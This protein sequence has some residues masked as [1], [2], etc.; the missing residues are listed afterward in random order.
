MSAAASRALLVRRRM[1]AAEKGRRRRTVLLSL[2][3]AAA[4]VA[5]GWWVVTGP[6]GRITS[7]EVTGYEGPRKALVVETIRRVAERGSVVDPPVEDLRRAMAAFPWVEDLHV[8]R[9]LP[10][11]ISVIVV[12]ATVGAVAVPDTG[13]PM[14]V[15]ASGR[16][17]GPLPRK[18]PGAPRVRVGTADLTV[19]ETLGGPVVASALTLSSR[20]TPKAAGRLVALHEAK[21]ALVGRL[22]A[23][24]VVRFGLMQD[25]AAKA[26]ALDLVLGQLSAEE[27]RAA[28]YID[29]SVPW[30]PAVGSRAVAQAAS[31]PP[32]VPAPA[33]EPSMTR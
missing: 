9:A 30:F 2:L 3:A 23:G 16:V 17:L 29:L 27:E 14:L 20:L 4:V 10:K 22:A 25:L 6:P 1:V 33:P 31:P 24:P 26:E 32:A 21:G 8:E 13:T 11:G 12:P 5:G 19:G 7:V 15:S 28:A 18:A